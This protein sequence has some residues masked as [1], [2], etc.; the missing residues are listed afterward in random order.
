MGNRPV[1][2]QELKV[3][4]QQLLV[5]KSKK[6]NIEQDIQFNP[7][8]EINDPELIEASRLGQTCTARS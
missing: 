7:A 5:Q 4:V 1:S 8:Y 3:K 2:L 6:N